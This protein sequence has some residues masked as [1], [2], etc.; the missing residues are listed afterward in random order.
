MKLV[1]YGRLAM[2]DD[3]GDSDQER[4]MEEKVRNITRRNRNEERSGIL[5]AAIWIAPGSI[6]VY[7]SSASHAG[8]VTSLHMAQPR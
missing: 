6:F 1:A 2:K 3:N 8:G 7:F 5:L 4:K